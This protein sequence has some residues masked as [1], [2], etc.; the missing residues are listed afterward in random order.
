M[1]SAGDDYPIH[2]R[3]EP[4]ALAGSDRNFY[5]RYYFQGYRADAGGYFGA[6]LG[7]YPHL[8][9]F[10]T[11][12]TRRIDPNDFAHVHLHA[13]CAAELRRPGRPPCRGQGVLEQMIVGA[14]APSAFHGLADVAG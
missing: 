5:D 1:L 14:H 3:P 2:Q 8:T 11:L 9:A 4:V 13:L 7:V 12:D 6:A 10:E